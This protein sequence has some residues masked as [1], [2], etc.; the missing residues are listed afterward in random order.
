MTE[1]IKLPTVGVEQLVTVAGGAFQPSVENCKAAFENGKITR[2]DLKTFEQDTSYRGKTEE[3][4]ACFGKAAWG[5]FGFSAE[6]VKKKF[7]VKD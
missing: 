4:R 3:S 5:G 7:G 2:Q 1:D 6:E